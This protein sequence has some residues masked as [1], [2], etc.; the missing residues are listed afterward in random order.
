MTTPVTDIIRDDPQIL[1]ATAARW[2]ADRI[3]AGNERFRI[4]LSGGSTP[5]ELY[6]LL[7]SSD[8]VIDWDK[9][10]LFWGDE[11]F[12]PATDARSNFRVVHEVLLSHVPIPAQNILPIPTDGTL[13]DAAARYEADIRREYEADTLDGKPPLFDLVLLGLGA[14]GHICSLFPNS[15]VLEERTKLV[16]AVPAGAPEP[17]I[18]LTFPAIESSRAIAFLVTG[19]EKAAIV[20]R[21]RGGDQALPAA[22]LKPKGEVFWFM[23]KVAAGK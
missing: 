9:V 18:T 19:P 8:Y 10:V 5:R 16:A 2:I 13:E 23:D 17:R 7:G 14:D 4:A 21:V 1:A 15:Q 3:A 22:R 20:A 6:T 11:R 12:V